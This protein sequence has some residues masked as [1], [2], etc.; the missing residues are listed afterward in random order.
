MHATLG[1][2]SKLQLTLVL[3]FWDLLKVTVLSTYDRNWFVHTDVVASSIDFDQERLLEL[4][5]SSISRT[6]PIRQHDT[7]MKAR[8]SAMDEDTPTMTANRKHHPAVHCRYAPLTGNRK[9]R[10]MAQCVTCCGVTPRRLRGG[11]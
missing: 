10:M 8:L 9:Y 2:N 3:M 6:A 5:H 7:S 11:V 4:Q 1:L